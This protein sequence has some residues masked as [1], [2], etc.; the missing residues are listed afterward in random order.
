[1][2]RPTKQHGA[3]GQTS[4]VEQHEREH[5]AR[6]SLGKHTVILP[7]CLLSVLPAHVTAPRRHAAV[8]G[9]LTCFVRAVPWLYVSEGVQ[10]LLPPLAPCLAPHP[11]HHRGAPQ[12]AAEVAPRGRGSSM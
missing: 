7:P 5:E 4:R 6:K 8:A 2:A 12:G 1:M 10:L 11:G 9:R 3:P